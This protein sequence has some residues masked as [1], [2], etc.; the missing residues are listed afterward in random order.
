[1]CGQSSALI[2]LR[3]SII[4]AFYGI[5]IASVGARSM[6]IEIATAVIALIV[7]GVNGNG[8]TVSG[9]CT[10]KHTIASLV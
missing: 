1:M 9:P 7:D 8:N 2:G 5:R 4:V 6:G 10:S 3:H